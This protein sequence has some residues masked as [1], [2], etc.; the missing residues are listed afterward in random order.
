MN[1][2]FRDNVVTTQHP[3]CPPEELSHIFPTVLMRRRMPDAKSKNRRLRKII[4]EREKNDSGVCHSNVGGWHSTPDLWDWPNPEVRD[5]SN[6]VKLAARELTA[7]MFPVQP[8]DE[9]LAEPY[10]GAWANVLREGGYN[11]VHNHPGAVWSAVY[12]VASGEPYAEP[13]GNG[14]FEFMDPRPGNVHGGKE[15]ITPEPGLLIMFP[16]W[17]QHYVNAYH[18]DGERI[19]IAWNLTVEIVR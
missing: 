18:G 15:V 1:T 5:L 13:P 7:G 10:G 8:G 9:V 12:Y 14:N 6:W 3:G 19:S 16:G 11:K 4:L 2:R 17:L